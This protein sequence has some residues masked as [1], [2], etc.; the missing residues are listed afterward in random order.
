MALYRISPFNS[1]FLFQSNI[2][3][4]F[5]ICVLNDW[6]VFWQEI[7]LTTRR[8]SSQLILLKYISIKYKQGIHL[9]FKVSWQILSF[10]GS[11]FYHFLS[12]I[13]KNHK[14][15]CPLTKFEQFHKCSFREFF[16]QCLPP[17]CKQ[18]KVNFSWLIKTKHHSNSYK[19]DKKRYK[20]LIVKHKK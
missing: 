14:K 8:H 5:S 18:V 2:Y 10:Y 9:R 1:A 15:E 17:V 13:Y 20:L 12:P 4:V 19:T 6:Q 7:S 3:M 11:F 16:I